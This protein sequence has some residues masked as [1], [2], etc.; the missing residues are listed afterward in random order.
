VLVLGIVLECLPDAGFDQAED[1][2]RD[3]DDADQRVDA[4]IVVQEDR[5]DFECLFEV[6][7][8]ALDDFLL[9]VEAQDLAG[10]QV[11]GEVGRER[12]D[13]VRMFLPMIC[14]T[15]RWTCVSVL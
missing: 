5:A 12:V 3:P 10:G 8:A 15:R 9:F 6:A 13:P 7:V 11:A 1:Q 2:Q 14:P 4:V